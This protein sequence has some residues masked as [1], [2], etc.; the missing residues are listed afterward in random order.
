MRTRQN[1]IPMKKIFYLLSTVVVLTVLSLSSCDEPVV[2]DDTD[3]RDSYIYTWNCQEQ[4][5][6]NYS[7]IVTAD[8]NNSSQ[9]LLANFH[10]FGNDQK[11]KAIATTNNLTLPSQEL[12]SNTI[13]GGGTLVNAN[14]IDMKYYVNNHSTIDTITATYTR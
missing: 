8:P 6:L 10:M 11:A 14:K 4:S 2:P 1:F 3:P 7:V 5:G 13:S 12:C 9:V